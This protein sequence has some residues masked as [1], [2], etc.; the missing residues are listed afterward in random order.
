MMKKAISIT[1]LSSAILVSGC[2]ST[3]G[4][5]TS[6]NGGCNTGMSTA[7]GALLGAA[8]GASVGDSTYAA[9]GAAIGGAVFAAGCMMINAHTIQKKSAAEVETAYKKANKG[10]LPQTTRVQQYS[11]VILPNQTVSAN[12]N[13]TVKS[14]LTVVEGIA[15]PLQRVQEKLVLKDANGKVIRELVKD[16]QVS[17]DQGYSS[18][19]FEN[20]FNWKFPAS[21]SKGQY[22]LDTELLVNGKKVANNSRTI[23]LI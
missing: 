20:S 1:M 19:D 18:G 15:D 4:L 7:V 12:Q 6:A 22:L 5:A 16:V 8:I 2:A 17:T 11:T 3:G 23:T 21:V 14:D 13:I 9:T 10:K